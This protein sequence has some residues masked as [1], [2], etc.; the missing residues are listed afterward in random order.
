MPGKPSINEYESTR[1]E[2]VEDSN[3]RYSKRLQ[4]ERSPEEVILAAQ[5]RFHDQGTVSR[6]LDA[7]GRPEK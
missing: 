2:Q 3:P 7:D 5:K 1:L 6:P 4:R